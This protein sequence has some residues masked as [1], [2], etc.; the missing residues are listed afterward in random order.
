MDDDLEL[1]ELLTEYLRPEG[2]GVDA[3]FDG[4]QGVNRALSGDY[5]LLILDVML[6]GIRGF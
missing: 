4:L 3:V 1:R 2:F 6:P 5:S